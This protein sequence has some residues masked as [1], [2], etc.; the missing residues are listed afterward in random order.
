MRSLTVLTILALV[1]GVARA[2]NNGPPIGTWRSDFPDGSS[3]TLVVQRS[4]DAM[5][6]P[7]GV[8]PVIGTASWR[9]TSAVGGILT[10]AYDNAGFRNYLYYSITWVDAKTIVLSDPGFRTTMRRR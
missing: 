6:A 9:A 5:F 10:I 2:A 1:L 3:L 7:S 8:Q 4:G